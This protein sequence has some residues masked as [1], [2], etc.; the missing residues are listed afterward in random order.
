MQLGA[1]RAKACVQ[2]VFHFP[3]H[4]WWWLGKSTA[5]NNNNNNNSNNNNKNSILTRC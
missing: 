3:Y 2:C 4:R 5:H 1:K